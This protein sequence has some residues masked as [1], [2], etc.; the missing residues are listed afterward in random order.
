M[1]QI[2]FDDRSFAVE[3]GE[4]VLDA[5]LRQGVDASYSCKSGACQSC[6]MRVEEGVPPQASQAG[7]KA[8]LKSRGYFLPCICK[9]TE[10][11][12]VTRPDGEADAQPVDARVLAV[13]PLSHDVAR[14][15]LRAGQDFDYRA[16]QFVNV[17]RSDGLVRSYSLA[18]L[19]T[20]EGHL[21]LHVR[22]IPNGRMSN[23]FHND[24]KPGDTVQVRGPAGDCFYLPDYR[25]QDLLMVGTGTGL[26][27]L[28]GILRDALRHDHQGHIHLY[29][30]ALDPAGL[31]LVDELTQLAADHPQ[32]VTYTRCVMRCDDMADP[33][34]ACPTDNC[35]VAVG[36]IDQ[37][38]FDHHPKLT[39]CRAYLCGNPG[40]VFT[41][42]KKVFLAGAGMKDIHSDAFIM[43]KP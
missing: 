24:V 34:L 26:A 41:L 23:W 38:I 36:A 6:L 25:E 5:L 29:H 43:A 32:H 11:L 30:G 35:R 31:Y 14:V 4:T 15:Y 13:E 37:V 12:T 39:G 7:L 3:S 20:T 28:V 22:R 1:P 10:D 18:N 21:E 2:A 8:S 27:P 9:P 16:G 40:L 19:P 17:M 42:R 33:A